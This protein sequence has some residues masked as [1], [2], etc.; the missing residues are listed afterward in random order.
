MILKDPK[1]LH[2]EHHTVVSTKH[3]ARNGK[4]ERQ[5][6]LAKDSGENIPKL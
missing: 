1:V 4:H 6:I 2:L 3:L 5:G